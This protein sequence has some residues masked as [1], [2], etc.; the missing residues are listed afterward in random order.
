LQILSTETVII[1][2]FDPLGDDNDDVRTEGDKIAL[3]FNTSPPF[4]PHQDDEDDKVD[5]VALAAMTRRMTV[6][7]G[8]R[9]SAVSPT[10]A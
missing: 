3:T 2:P 9:A 5:M 6:T 7:D 8:E 4:H 10:P 1:D